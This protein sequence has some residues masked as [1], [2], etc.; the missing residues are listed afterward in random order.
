M[1]ILPAFNAAGLDNRARGVSVGRSLERNKGD[2][3]GE[4]LHEL[5]Q[6]DGAVALVLDAVGVVGSNPIAPTG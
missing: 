6:R 1:I 4:T 5:L 3:N 2:S